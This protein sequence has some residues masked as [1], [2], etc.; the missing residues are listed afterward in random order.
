MYIYICIYVFICIYIYVYICIHICI[1][2]YLNMYVCIYMYIY[3]YVHTYI[4]IHVY[5]YVYIYIYTHLFTYVHIYICIHIAS[6]QTTWGHHMLMILVSNRIAMKNWSVHYRRSQLGQR[7]LW[8]GYN[9][10]YQAHKLGDNPEKTIETDTS[11]NMTGTAL[12][13][14]SMPRMGNVS[15]F[16]GNWYHQWLDSG[17]CHPL[18]PRRQH[19]LYGQQH[20][21]SLRNVPQPGRTAA[22]S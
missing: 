16:L 22:P 18:G 13:K 14:K 11:T 20:L 15:G 3:V 17:G 2:I 12:E 7:L 8:T 4:Y 9:H 5:I 6:I 19:G 21:F 10:G 1:Y